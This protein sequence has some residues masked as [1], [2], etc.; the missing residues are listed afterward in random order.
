MNNANQNTISTARTSR[1]FLFA[2]CCA[3]LSAFILATDLLLSTQ[4]EMSEDTLEFWFLASMFVALPAAVAL[5]LVRRPLLLTV[6]GIASVF[7][8]GII[9]GSI[10][11]SIQDPS[12]SNNLI[13]FFGHNVLLCIASHIMWTTWS[14]YLFL[15]GKLGASS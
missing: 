7:S 14:G 4:I 13:W 15:S 10:M 8:W 2:G 3:L 1:F 6:V 9:L 12:L 11:L 5:C